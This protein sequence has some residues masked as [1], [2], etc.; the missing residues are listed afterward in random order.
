MYNI[1]GS[2]MIGRGIPKEVG[3][4]YVYVFLHITAAH[5]VSFFTNSFFR[6]VYIWGDDRTWDSKG[7]GIPRGFLDGIIGSGM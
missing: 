7:S 3:F 4:L 1:F 2:G 6:Q 5:D